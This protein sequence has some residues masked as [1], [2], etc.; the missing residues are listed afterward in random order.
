M[1]STSESTPFYGN[2]SRTLSIRRL[3]HDEATRVIDLTGIAKIRKYDLQELIDRLP[4][5][6]GF[7]DWV[8]NKPDLF[9]LMLKNGIGLDKL[10]VEIVYVEITD[11]NTYKQ[12]PAFL[13]S[14]HM[15]SGRQVLCGYGYTQA[16]DLVSK[17]EKIEIGKQIVEHLI[18]PEASG[19]VLECHVSNHNQPT[20]ALWQYLAREFYEDIMIGFTP[21]TWRPT[22][23]TTVTIERK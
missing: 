5:E 20:L 19:Q 17:R 23:Y 22:G 9:S 14:K 7:L 2:K 15:V 1:P 11:N 18:I 13:A 4:R 3:E 8:L 21:S 6:G 12:T 16:D 10:E